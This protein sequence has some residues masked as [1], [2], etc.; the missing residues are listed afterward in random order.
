MRSTS[1]SL[2]PSSFSTALPKDCVISCVFTLRMVPLMMMALWKSPFALGIHINVPTLPPPPD[3]PK[4][5][6]FVG[7]P[8]K[9]LMLSRTHSNACTTSSIPT[10][11]EYLYFSETADRSKKPR[12]F[13]RWFTLTTTTSFFANCC[14]GSHADVPESKPPPCSHTIT[15][16]CVEGEVPVV[17]SP[18]SIV[19]TFST[20]QFSDISS[21]LNVLPQVCCIA[22]GPQWSQALTP[23]HLSTGCGGMKRSTLA[24]GI[25]RKAIVPSCIVPLIRPDVV[26]ITC[27]E[28]LTAVSSNPNKAKSFF[29]I[30][31]DC[32]LQR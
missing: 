12:M 5:V 32:F 24:Y 3:S 28:A 29:L 2:M 18:S 1:V 26:F 25:P 15:G 19:Q 21:S 30:T 10:L 22:C 13:S 23:S 20:Q 11:P 7:S 8:P 31:C 17:R 6:T 9:L 16:L 27:A 14:P 4:M